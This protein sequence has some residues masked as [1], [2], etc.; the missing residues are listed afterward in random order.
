M[1][2]CAA[3]AGVDEAAHLRLQLRTTLDYPMRM[4]YDSRSFSKSKAEVYYAQA[5][6]R[7]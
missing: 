5:V 1:R 4:T 2:K 7:T 3:A 6:A